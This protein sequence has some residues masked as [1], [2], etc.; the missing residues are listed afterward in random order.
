LSNYRKVSFQSLR[1][2]VILTAP[3]SA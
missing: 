1:Q 3:G 2:G